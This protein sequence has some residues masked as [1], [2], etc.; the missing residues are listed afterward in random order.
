[1]II[2]KIKVMV[3]V[4]INMENQFC[5]IMLSN[6]KKTVNLTKIISPSNKHN[7]TIFLSL[8]KG[9]LILILKNLLK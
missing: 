4:S 2:E 6:K 8:F 1:M 7:F 5:R 9:F 3:L